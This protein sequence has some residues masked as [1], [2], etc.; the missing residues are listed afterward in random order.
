[1]EADTLAPLLLSPRAATA[2]LDSVL[3]L[4]QLHYYPK[5]SHELHY[6]P[7]VLHPCHHPADGETGEAEAEGGGRGAAGGAAQQVP[8]YGVVHRVPEVIALRVRSPRRRLIGF[9]QDRRLQASEVRPAYE[10]WVLARL[11][12]HLSAD[13]GGAA[14]C[15]AYDSPAAEANGSLCA[16]CDRRLTALCACA[17]EGHATREGSSSTPQFDW[18]AARSCCLLAGAGSGVAGALWYVARQGGTEAS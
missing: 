18:G 7:R 13:E 16:S 2:G 3:L 10:R 8:Y 4:H 9:L 6:A 17:T 12:A 15:A 11:R 1:M 5:W 14:P